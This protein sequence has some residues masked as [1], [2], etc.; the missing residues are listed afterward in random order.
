[1][2]KDA[3][4]EHDLQLVDCLMVTKPF[5]ESFLLKS[6]L[7]SISFCKVISLRAID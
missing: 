3:L 6:T 4:L 5:L 1:M 2:V 7:C